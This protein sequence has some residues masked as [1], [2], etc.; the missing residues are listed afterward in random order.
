MFWKL[1]TLAL[2]LLKLL[3]KLEFPTTKQLTTKQLV[4]WMQEKTVQPLVLDARTQ[5]EYEVSHLIAAQRLDPV[6]PDFEAISTMPKDTPIVVYC[7][8]GYRSTK[9]AQQLEQIGFSSV[10]N[11]SG[12][13]F[14]WAN[15]GRPIYKDGH[16]AQLVHPYNAKWGKLLKADKNFMESNKH[17]YLGM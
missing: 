6:A 8:I 11:L 5:A 12:G 4:Q 17:L 14:Q 3:I 2:N 16:P 7:S 10:F 1:H 13:I 9:I 15:E